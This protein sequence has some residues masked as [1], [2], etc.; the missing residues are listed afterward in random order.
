M[1]SARQV[2]T[3]ECGNITYFPL[4]YILFIYNA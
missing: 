1:Y 3:N 2:A 4:T